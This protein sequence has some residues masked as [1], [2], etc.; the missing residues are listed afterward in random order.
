MSDASTP[1]PGKLTEVI[2]WDIYQDRLVLACTGLAET[3]RPSYPPVALLKMSVIARPYGFS[4]RQ[5]EEATNYH[6]RSRR[7]WG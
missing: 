3:D 5:V 1:F 4:E 7:C 2:N 6:R